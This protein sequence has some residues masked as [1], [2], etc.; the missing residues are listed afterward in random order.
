[1]QP[2]KRAVHHS[3]LAT[4]ILI[5][6]V[7][8]APSIG[9]RAEGVSGF[10]IGGQVQRP[11]HVTTDDLEKFDKTEVSVSY[12]T[13]HGHEAGSYSG[14]LLWTLLSKAELKNGPEKGA[15]LRHI[16]LVTGR[17]GYAVAISS[18]ELA[19]EF[20]N[21]SVIIATQKDGKPLSQEDGV[22]L[23]IPGDKHGGRAVR[24]VVRIDVQ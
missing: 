18:G 9:A 22:R 20:E 7:Q 13:G 17:D 24:D 23:I 2:T 8:T 3:I 16:I 14:I 5:A 21:K 15:L 1:M 4:L 19:P 12:M 10:T 6:S 11:Q